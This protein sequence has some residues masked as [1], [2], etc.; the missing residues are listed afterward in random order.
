MKTQLKEDIMGAF[1]NSFE[2]AS[3]F[4]LTENGALTFTS[5]LNHNLDFFSMASAKRGDPSGAVHLFTE[6]YNEDPKLAILNAFYCR[7]VR[8]GQGERNIFR[9][10]LFHVDQKYLSNPKFLELIPEYGR[11]D[12]LFDLVHKYSTNIGITNAI[13]DIVYH[14]IQKD[15]VSSHPSLCAKWFPLAN[16]VSSPERKNTARMLCR[17]LGWSERDARKRIVSIRK[18]IHLIEQDLTERNIT[19]PLENVPSR[20]F[21]K[22][23]NAF[24]RIIPEKFQEFIERVAEGKAKI[25]ANCIYPYEIVAELRNEIRGS[26]WF[27]TRRNGDPTILATLCES[28]KSLPEYSAKG[29]VL[30]V[31]DV[32]GSMFQQIS[33]GSS[34]QAIDVSTSL[35][36]Y[37]AEHNSGIFKDHYISFS[38][39]PKLLKLNPNMNLAQKLEYVWNTEVGYDT[40]F[41]AVFTTIL[42]A[43]RRNN[44][45]KEECPSTILVISDMEFNRVGDGHTNFEYIKDQYK[46]AGY[47]LPQLVFWNVMSRGLN[48]PVRKDQNG[49]I[50]LSGVSPSVL[51]FISDSDITPEKFMMDVL[52]SERY[53]PVREVL[54]Y[55]V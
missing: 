51:R 9:G 17:S 54:G 26:S 7:D 52:F 24:M 55:R 18:K 15:L 53:R 14:Q 46:R 30:T 20:A 11:W 2:E 27:E 29:N 47:D 48:V 10:C 39:R 22:Y 1:L 4:G 38:A 19:M 23:K 6:A 41:A 28:W 40:N 3:T 45:P 21:Q 12:D 13:V 36:I 8:G 49:T 50:L 32:S 44:L 31:V 35:G 25:N 43:M 34:A 42:D 33:P 37:T 5:T 16:S